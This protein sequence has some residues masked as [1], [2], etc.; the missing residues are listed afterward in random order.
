MSLL[1]RID[2]ERER[3]AY[4]P[5]DVPADYGRGHDD[6]M[7]SPPEYGDYIATSSQIYSVAQLRA[8]LVSSVMPRFYRGRG[9]DK[10]EVA[11]SDPAVALLRYVNPH[12]TWT[13]LARMDELSRCLW[14]ET[15]WAV[16][17]D[18]RTPREIW[19]LKPTRVRPLV[20]ANDYIAGYTY[21][22]LNGGKPLV[23]RADE[24]VWQRYPNPIDEFSAL[25]PLAAARQGA[26]T[27]SAMMRSN[28]KLFD[29]G[30]HIG[31][32]VVPDTGKVTFSSEQAKELEALLDNRFKGPDKAHRW[33]VLRYEAQ[34]RP[35]NIT[36]K[37]AQF[38]AGLNL[39]LRD[40][41]N[42]FGVPSPML[43]DMEHATL[44]NAREFER[45]L[46]TNALVPDLTLMADEIAEQYLPKFAATRSAPDHVAFDFSTVAALQESQSEAWS[47]EYEA[48]E[49][50]AMTIN[51]WRKSKGWPPV[52]WGDVWWA[53]VN[54]SPVDNSSLKP[55]PETPAAGKSYEPVRSVLN[56][57]SVE[58]VLASLNGRH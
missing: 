38:S 58:R 43:N 11:E 56:P 5:R 23:F 20:H 2:E 33:A 25:S 26:D 12:W 27:G 10:L 34:F 48:L 35:M 42:A 39:T 37:D 6:S 18:G 15:F 40:V 54:K 31:G 51:E 29:N 45:F 24:I 53:P 21:E 17:R 28:K 3:R 22:P 47:R 41:C 49:Q 14:G 50:G 16:E 30:L 36:P 57:H 32:L 1:D 52:P 8:R 19:W 46:W 4:P 9:P 55:A 7:F 13:R 44:A